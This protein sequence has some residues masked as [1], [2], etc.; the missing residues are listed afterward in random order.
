MTRQ[1]R[2]GLFHIALVTAA[3]G[4][5]GFGLAGLPDL[6]PALLLLILALAFVGEWLEIRIGPAGSFT[7][8]PAVAF[9]GLWAGGPA[10]MMLAGVIPSLAVQTILR[11]ASLRDT[12]AISGRDAL[13]FWFGYAVYM[14]VGLWVA[15]AA[16]GSGTGEMLARVVGFVCFWLVQIPL[17]A[18]LMSL[19]EGIQYRVIWR[20]IA[21]NAWVHLAAQTGGAVFLASVAESF[22]LVVMGF[23]AVMLVEAYYPWKLLGEQ[24]GVLLTSLQMMAQAVDLKDSYTSNHSQRVAQCAVRLARALGLP[25]EEVERI[26][27]GALMHDIG[28]IGVSGRIIRKPAGLTGEEQ[29]AM[30]RHSSMSADIIGPLEILGESARI[31]RH[32]H[33][34]WDGRGYPDGLG[35]EEIPFGSRVIFVADAFD[36]LTSDRPYRRGKARDEAVAII[37][38][39][40]GAQFDEVVV[41]ALERIS[42]LL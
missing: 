25:E 1:M 2:S 28:K 36:A 34:R 15:E 39:N 27:I 5:V 22:G 4:A 6:E 29:A 37:R 26:R 31:V 9:V 14:R 13:G 17:Q 33:E 23:G 35:G 38:E 8:R 32:H 3:G 30:M 42:P 10:L 7:L 19:E 20:H 18:V 16:W 21:R 24:S 11:K 40:A 41:Q 12:L